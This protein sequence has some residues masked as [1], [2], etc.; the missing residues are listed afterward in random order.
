M[1]YWDRLAE[2]SLSS[3]KVRRPF[4]RFGKLTTDKLKIYNKPSSLLFCAHSIAAA[5]EW[6]F[7]GSALTINHER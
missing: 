4:R 7:L 3:K 5:L 6:D 1:D 2:M